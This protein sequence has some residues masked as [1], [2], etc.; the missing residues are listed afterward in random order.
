MLNIEIIIFFIWWYR[1]LSISL[2]RK[3]KKY[4]DYG[5]RNDYL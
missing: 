5:K 2:Q 3:T 1:Y 4:F